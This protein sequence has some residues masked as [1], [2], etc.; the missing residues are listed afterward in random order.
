MGGG[1]REWREEEKG[2]E[3]KRKGGREEEKGRERKRKNWPEEGEKENDSFTFSLA[4][5]SHDDHQ[6]L[7]EGRS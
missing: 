7:L 1:R 6:L 4:D 5:V 3:R 2:R